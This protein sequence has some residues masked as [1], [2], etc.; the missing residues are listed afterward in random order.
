MGDDKYVQYKADED[1]CI[2]LYNTELRK[3][4]RICDIGSPSELPISVIRQVR[5]DKKRAAVL[6]DV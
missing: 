5:A 1:K 3:W 6:P 4:Q 2:Y